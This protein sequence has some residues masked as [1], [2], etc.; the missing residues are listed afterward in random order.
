MPH[1]LEGVI[2]KLRKKIKVGL[3]SGHE[4]A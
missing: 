2:E 4:T 3:W 1:G